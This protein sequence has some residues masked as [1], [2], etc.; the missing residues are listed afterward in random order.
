MESEW[1]DALISGLRSGFRTGFP[2]GEAF[3]GGCD[4]KR[5]GETPFLTCIGWAAACHRML[6]AAIDTDSVKTIDASLSSDE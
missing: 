2:G 4:S 1:R 5:A 3:D 6:L